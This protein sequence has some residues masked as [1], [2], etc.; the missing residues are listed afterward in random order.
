M[1]FKSSF[2]HPPQKRQLLLN[3]S[4]STVVRDVFFHVLYPCIISTLSFPQVFGPGHKSKEA[5]RDVFLFSVHI[6]LLGDMLFVFLL[7]SKWL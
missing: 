2:L 4:P 5:W 6:S 3:L 7:R 1:A